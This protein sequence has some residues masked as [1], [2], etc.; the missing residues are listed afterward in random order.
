MASWGEEQIANER[1]L[2]LGLRVSPRTVR[3]YMPRRPPRT[4]RGDQRRSTFLHN[5]AQAIVACDF[6][7]AVAFR[8][9]YILVVIEHGTGRVLH[10]NVTAHPTAEWTPQ[11]LQEAFPSEYEYRFLIHDRYTIFS[12]NTP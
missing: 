8:V 10:C 11:Q 12:K 2:K 1:L 3:K 9:L 4:P 5:H 6:C 7:I